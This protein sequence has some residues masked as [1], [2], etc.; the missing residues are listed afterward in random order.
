MVSLIFGRGYLDNAS[1]DNTGKKNNLVL[2][3]Q[4][5]VRIFWEFSIRPVL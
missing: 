4:N 1:A 5:S 3:K 2:N